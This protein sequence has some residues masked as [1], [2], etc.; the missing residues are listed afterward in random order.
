M[1]HA[2]IEVFAFLLERA[3]RMP[4]SEYPRKGD[5]LALGRKQMLLPELG[6]GENQII[7]LLGDGSS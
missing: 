5:E 3:G 4:V 7:Y 6:K 2:C 1:L